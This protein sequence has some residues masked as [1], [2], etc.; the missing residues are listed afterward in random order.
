MAAPAAPEGQKNILTVNSL[1]SIYC[2]KK[3]SDGNQ[4]GRESPLIQREIKECL[5]GDIPQVP[6]W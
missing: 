6:L 1:Q 5:E 4:T 2:F 3:S